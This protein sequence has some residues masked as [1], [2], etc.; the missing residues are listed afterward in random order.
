MK[1]AHPWLLWL[2]PPA[3]AGIGLLLRWADRRRRRLLDRFTGD[4]GRYWS[5]TGSSETRRRLG[6]VLALGSLAFLLAALAR[7]LLYSKEHQNELQ[8]I[9]YLFALDASRSM[10][11][12]DVRPNRYGVA[13]NALDRW[14]AEVRADR[15]GLITFAGE[16]YL[17]APLTFDTEALRTVLR[18]LEPEDIFEGGSALAKSIERTA[19]YFVSNNVPRRLLIIISDGEELEGNAIETARRCRREHDMVTC[20]LGVGT[21]SGAKVP[22]NRKGGAWGNAR[23]SFGQEVTTRLD[24]ANLKRIANAGGGR[25]FPLGPNGE[26]LDHLREQ[27][28]RPMAEAAAKDNLQ[29][30]LEMYQIPL[31]LS[32]FCI[33]AHLWLRP[34]SFQR[35]PAANGQLV[36]R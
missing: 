18:F 27:V 15:V 14:L 25:Y 29:N 13:S 1:F 23:N 3:L 35:R 20:T 26:G 17:N 30:Y 2:I 31:A 19:A 28:L 11:A 24:E 5:A 33:L 6:L 10:L 12:G 21:S 7:P 4:P 36:I 34:D 16:A 22:A 8:G 32:L 9:P